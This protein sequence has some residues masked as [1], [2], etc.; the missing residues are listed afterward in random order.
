MR[1]CRENGGITDYIN[2][3]DIQV[4]DLYPI[5]EFVQHLKFQKILDRY[6]DLYGMDMFGES[7]KTWYY[8]NENTVLPENIPI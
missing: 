8:I 2:G 4:S 6:D 3:E 5:T 7:K 1:C